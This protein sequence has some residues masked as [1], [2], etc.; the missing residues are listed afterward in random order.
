MVNEECSFCW[1]RWNWS[2]ILKIFFIL[3]VIKLLYVYISIKDWKIALWIL[4]NKRSF[5]D[6]PQVNK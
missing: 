6:T 5:T 1:Y 2:T 3:H 4:L